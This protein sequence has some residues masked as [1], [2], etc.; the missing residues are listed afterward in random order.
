MIG[1]IQIVSLLAAV[2]LFCMCV[3]LVVLGAPDSVRSGLFN[4][5][6]V[7]AILQWFCSLERRLTELEKRKTE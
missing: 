5:M 1:Y 7:F 3:A 6:S 2:L 4:A